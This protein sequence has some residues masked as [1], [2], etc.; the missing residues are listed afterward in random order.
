MR[1]PGLPA[2]DS[3]GPVVNEVQVDLRFGSVEGDDPNLTFG[4]I[5]GVEAASDGTI[6]VLDYLAAEVRAYSPDGE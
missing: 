4:D 6:Y 2:I 3:V 1:Y 5:R